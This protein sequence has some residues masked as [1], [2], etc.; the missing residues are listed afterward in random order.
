VP[1]KLDRIFILHPLLTVKYAEV[2]AISVVNTIIEMVWNG[3]VL[4]SHIANRPNEHK[5]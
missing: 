5:N 1:S 4:L 3:I 2:N